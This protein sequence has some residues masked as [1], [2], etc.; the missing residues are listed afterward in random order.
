M[1]EYVIQPG[2]DVVTRSAEV[3]RMTMDVNVCES[4]DHEFPPLLSTQ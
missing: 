3:S 4:F 1:S 2:F